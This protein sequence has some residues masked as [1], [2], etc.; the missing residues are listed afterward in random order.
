MKGQFGLEAFFS[1]M[2]IALSVIA[3]IIILNVPAIGLNSLKGKAEE[4]LEG[5]ELSESNMADLQL[6][7]YLRTIIPDNLPEMIEQTSSKNLDLGINPGKAAEFF[8]ANKEMYKGNNYADLIAILNPYEKEERQ[9]A[10]AAATRALFSTEIAGIYDYPR[11]SVV[12]GD[13]PANYDQGDLISGSVFPGQI[14]QQ[15]IPLPKNSAFVRLH[16]GE[17]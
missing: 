17:K 9:N 8:R 16:M 6:N 12:Y 4:K 3:V 7:A 15:Q 5:K 14:V 1:Y 2:L 10:F 13:K 11:I